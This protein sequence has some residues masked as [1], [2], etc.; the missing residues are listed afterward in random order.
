M[1]LP[2]VVANDPAIRVTSD[3]DPK[4]LDEWWARWEQLPRTVRDRPAADVLAELRSSD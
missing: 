4:A 1:A 2:S 3:A